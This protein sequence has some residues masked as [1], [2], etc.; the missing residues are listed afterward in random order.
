MSKSTKISIEVSFC[1]SGFIYD[2]TSP[3]G[4]LGYPMFDLTPEDRLQKALEEV[5]QLLKYCE[6]VAVKEAIRKIK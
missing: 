5:E 6:D 2:F 3:A 1:D 4:V